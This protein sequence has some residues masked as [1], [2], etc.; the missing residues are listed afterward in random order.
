MS[1]GWRGGVFVVGALMGVCGIALWLSGGG[2]FLLAMA[3]IVLIAGALEPVYGRL[4]GRPRSGNWRAT[5][6]KFVDPE[7][8]ELV[9]V[10]FDPTTG[11]RRY[12]ADQGQS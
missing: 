2:P 11:E 7:T 1:G 3:V 12:V 4:V 8:G 5:G 10:W 6:E 9:T